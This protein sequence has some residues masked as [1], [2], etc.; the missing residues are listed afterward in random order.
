[1]EKRVRPEVGTG[2]YDYGESGRK[3]ERRQRALLVVADGVG[4]PDYGG[5]WTRMALNRSRSEQEWQ[6]QQRFLS[7]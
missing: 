3:Q 1:M 6:R 5:F 2:R 4:E 7:D